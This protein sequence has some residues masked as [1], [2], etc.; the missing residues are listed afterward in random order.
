V[1]GVRTLHKKG[2]S[3]AGGELEGGEGQSQVTKKR[4][5]RQERGQALLSRFLVGSPSFGLSP[6]NKDE[7]RTT[8]LGVIPE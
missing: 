4:R 8:F 5:L 3:E 6:Q 2:V 1:P 7:R